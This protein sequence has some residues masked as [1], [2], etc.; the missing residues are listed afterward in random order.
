MI[1][2]SSASA[3]WESSA[4]C[5]CRS[6]APSVG[7]SRKASF[8][9]ASASAGC[10]KRTPSSSVASSWAAAASSA[11]SRSSSTGTSSLTRRSWGPGGRLLL[12]APHPLA[13]VVELGLQPLQ[14]V[15]ILVAL[16]HGRLERIDLRG[17][18]LELDVVG[19]LV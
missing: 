19:A 10:N 8:A 16:L 9:R 15:E 2:P 6:N 12:V 7:I 3:G 5:V 13:V 17:Y 18:L 4:S 1:V 11:R 14:R